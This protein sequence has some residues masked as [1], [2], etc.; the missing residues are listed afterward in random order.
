M[1]PKEC[2]KSDKMAEWKIKEKDNLIKEKLGM[3]DRMSSTTKSDTFI[4]LKN[5]MENF[6]TSFTCQLMNP[7]SP[8][9]G[10]VSKQTWETNLARWQNT[11]DVIK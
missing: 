1:H 11:T 10:K 2:K 4:T 8:D 3:R 7:C 6:S 5:K 9:L